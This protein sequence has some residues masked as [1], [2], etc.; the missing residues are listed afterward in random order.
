MN[1]SYNKKKYGFLFTSLALI[2]VAAGVVAGKIIKTNNENTLAASAHIEVINNDQQISRDQSTDATVVEQQSVVTVRSQ[3]AL[4]GYVLSAKLTQDAMLAASVTISSNESALCPVELPCELSATPQPILSVSSDAAVDVSGD[5]T[6]FNLV[7]TIPAM[8]PTSDY[9]LDIEYA[10][11]ALPFAGLTDGADAQSVTREMCDLTPLGTIV[12]LKDTRD[13]KYYRVKRMVDGNCWMIDN[14]AFDLSNS[15]APAYDPVAV[16]EGNR[17][18]TWAQYSPNPGYTIPNNGN[19]TPSYLYNWCAALGDTSTNC[20]ASAGA[21][22]YETV[23]DGV[24]VAGDATNQPDAVGI[25]PAPFRLPKGGP[26]ASVDNPDATANEFVRLDIAM[27]GRAI[28][29][30]YSLWMGSSAAGD[31]WEGVLGGYWSFGGLWHQDVLAYWWSSTGS[32]N[33]GVYLL[34]VVKSGSQV[35]P[36]GTDTNFYGFPVRCV[37]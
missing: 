31:T 4:Y 37:L 33:S 19:P 35:M 32:G 10:E 25:C 28:V 26:D 2:C 14:L 5:T 9:V 15:N 36:A 23:I 8:T 34:S 7:I 20:S 3:D 16:L 29:D 11:E 18:S 17:T 6:T 22:Q 1:I 27:G 12:N 30:T 13:G 21:A 24:A